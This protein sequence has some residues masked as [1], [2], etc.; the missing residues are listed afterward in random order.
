MLLVQDTD[1]FKIAFKWFSIK[2]SS[3]LI[4]VPLWAL[5]QLLL[6][7]HLKFFWPDSNRLVSGLIE[8]LRLH[9]FERMRAHKHAFQAINNDSWE[10]LY[11]K[12]QSKSQCL[13]LFRSIFNWTAQQINKIKCIIRHYVFSFAS[14]YFIIF[15]WLINNHFVWNLFDRWLRARPR[16]IHVTHPKRVHRNREKLEKSESES[17]CVCMREMETGQKASKRWR[18]HGLKKRSNMHF[19]PCSFYFSSRI[20]ATANTAIKSTLNLYRQT[21]K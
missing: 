21:P 3:S 14:F 16:K 17:E 10:N 4:V 18:K 11:L 20:I 2:W 15:K 7:C 13:R 19:I 1:R 5:H 12:Q 9:S 8:A 6:L